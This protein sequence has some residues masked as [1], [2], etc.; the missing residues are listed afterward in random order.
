MKNI[1]LFLFLPLQLILSQGHIDTLEYFPL[2]T[3]DHWEYAPMDLESKTF[4]FDTIIGDTLMAN[5]KI[6][7]ILKE[8]YSD[9]ND[10]HYIF[11]RND[12]DFVYN[13]SGIYDST[14]CPEGEYI[15]YNFTSRDSVIWPI[16]F[17]NF[18]AEYKSCVKTFNELYGIFTTVSETKE[19]VYVIPSPGDT[20]WSPLSTDII[21][22]AK[23]IGVIRK[24]GE[25]YFYVL[26]GVV[27]NGK[28][29]GT[30]V[31]V[32]DKITVPMVYSLSQN[33]PNP[34]N[35]S[36]TIKYSL[37]KEG[38]I[39]LTV[40]NSIGSKVATIVDGYKPSGNYSVQFNGSNLASGIYLYRLESGN[41]S[42]AKK[43]IL[44]K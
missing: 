39:K 23:N 17:N 40:Y 3:G 33:F 20:I 25:T 7:K 38:F 10:V 9:F 14:K 34:F 21:D 43:F 15:E 16:C 19:F 35:P 26:N 12:G 11:Y 32:K 37:A 28:T 27:L 6:Y 24:M 8:T 1:I 4:I 41:Y 30:L 2:Q 42:S 29:Y 44:Q 18:G 22:I 13:Y 36:T 31:G 5:G